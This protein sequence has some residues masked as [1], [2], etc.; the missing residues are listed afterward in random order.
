M[1]FVGLIIQQADSLDLILIANYCQCPMCT[2]WYDL[3]TSTGLECA[4]PYGLH[5]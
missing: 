4:K 1:I 5:R 2:M 3:E